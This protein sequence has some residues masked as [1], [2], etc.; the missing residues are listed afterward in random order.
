MKPT[1][2]SQY[3][4]QPNQGYFDVG[5]TADGRQVL[6]GALCPHLVAVFFD[7]SGDLLAVQTRLLEFLKPSALIVDGKPLEGLVQTYDIAD[8]R[9]EM[10]LH[11]WRQELGFQPRDIVVKKFFIA[12]L[13]LGIE[14]YPSHLE[15]VLSD[16]SASDEKKQEVRAAM[17]TWDTDGQ[18]VLLWGNDYWL[19]QMG[20][21]T[22]S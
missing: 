15:D 12:E 8:E 14:D 22:S 11:T 18:F 10:H 13:E 9:I 5:T 20:E 3:Q 16:P 19:D 1:I 2:R 21:V 4:I 6:L 7:S 17:Q